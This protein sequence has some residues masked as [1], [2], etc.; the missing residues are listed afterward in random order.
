M[1][2]QAQFVGSAGPCPFWVIRG[3][4]VETLRCPF[5]RFDPIATTKMLPRRHPPVRAELRRPMTPPAKPPSCDL[6]RHDEHTLHPS[7]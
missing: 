2:S 1:R 7:L 3:L 6:E 5:V 4:A